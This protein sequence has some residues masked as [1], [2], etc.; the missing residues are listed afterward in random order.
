MN[1]REKLQQTPSGARAK[2]SGDTRVLVTDGQYLHTLGIVRW[3]G[4]AGMDV[5]VIAPTPSAPSLHSRFCRWGFVNPPMDNEEA[6]LS[7]LENILHGISFDLLVPVGALATRF[8]S[9]HRERLAALV[10]FQVA[11]HQS[12]ETAFNKKATYALAEQL[13]IRCPRTVYP[14]SIAEVE[15]LSLE[16]EYP[17]VIKALY[18]EGTNVVRYPRNR[19]GLL[20]LYESLCTERGYAPPRLPML[21]EF[22]FS[23]DIGYSFSALYQNG[24]CKRVFMYREIRSIPV[25]GG[26]SAY[27]ESCFDAE[28]KQT[29]VQL[30][31]ALDWNG[32]AQIDF[33]RGTDGKLY[34]MEINPK[35]WASLEVALVAGVNF[36]LLLCNMAAGQ[37]LGYSEEYRRGTRYHWPLSRELLHLAGRPASLPAVLWA[38]LDPGTKSNVWISDP[39][40]NV[41][42]FAKTLAAFSR[43]LPDLD[44]LGG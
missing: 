42:E 16:L 38:C 29:G 12:I 26:S 17:I 39:K 31:D 20:Q 6:F 37:E 14:Q 34:L 40:P 7:F 2:G 43:Q 41:L 21:Q 28:L 10:R 13:G 4:R 23:D 9:K 1:E 22:I 32:V 30:L 5:G 11:D 24:R 44:K 35:F 33:R 36:P 25:Q 15:R 19:A 27:A 3:L 18:E 8:V